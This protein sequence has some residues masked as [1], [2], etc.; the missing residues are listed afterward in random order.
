MVFENIAEYQ[1][2]ANQ[3]YRNL[4]ATIGEDDYEKD[5]AGR[6]I[7]GISSHIVAALTTCFFV[8][9]GSFDNSV[10][11]RLFEE[12][13][14]ELMLRWKELDE[15]LRKMIKD[16]PKGFV[17]VSHVSETPVRLDFM[18]FLLQYILHTNHHR[19]QEA[20][21]AGSTLGVRRRNRLEAS[22]PYSC[23]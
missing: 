18:D 21:Q 9:E 14:A 10:Y 1:V 16:E 3:K 12:S 19:G 4:I 2:W 20:Y 11:E 13:R 15:L 6:N 8:I 22:T 5:V 7:R 17:T 23:P